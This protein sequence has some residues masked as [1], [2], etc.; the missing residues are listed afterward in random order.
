M[1]KEQAAG[2]SQHGSLMGS[3]TIPQGSGSSRSPLVVFT[4]AVAMS[5]PFGRAVSSDAATEMIKA[6]NGALDPK[7]LPQQPGGGGLGLGRI[8]LQSPGDAAALLVASTVLS[9]NSWQWISPKL[10]KTVRV[11]DLG[12]SK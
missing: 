5:V 8:L 7:Q 1:L 11:E 3:G 4:E 6:I 10:I 12:H 9:C 2:S